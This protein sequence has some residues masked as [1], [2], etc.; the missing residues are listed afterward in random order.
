MHYMMLYD[1][2][3]RNIYYKYELQNREVIMIDCNRDL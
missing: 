2:Q 3:N 1:L